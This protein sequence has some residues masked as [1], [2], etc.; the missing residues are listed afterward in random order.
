[1]PNEDSGNCMKISQLTIAYSRPK[2]IR[3]YLCPIK[4]IETDN[5]F[6]SKYVW[7]W[8]MKKM[9]IYI[10]N[11][12]NDNLYSKIWKSIYISICK[13][14]AHGWL[15]WIISKYILSLYHPQ[16]YNY[17]LYSGQNQSL[18]EKKR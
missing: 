7:K 4:L 17:M 16:L 6:V 18:Q 10:W 5:V 8:K 1:M 11:F 13:D 15:K 3:N 14:L 2:N 12:E 9:M